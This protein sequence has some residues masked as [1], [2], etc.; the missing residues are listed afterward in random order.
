MPLVRREHNQARRADVICRSIPRPTLHCAYARA[1]VR[2][3][4][5]RKTL[6]GTLGQSFTSHSLSFCAHISKLVS[7]PQTYCLISPQ[8]RAAHGHAREACLQV[9]P[10][11]THRRRVGRSHLLGR[12]PAHPPLE[13][14]TR[15]VAIGASRHSARARRARRP[16]D[17]VWVEHSGRPPKVALGEHDRVRARQVRH[18]IDDFAVKVKRCA[19]PKVRQ[20]RGRKGGPSL[21]RGKAGGPH[22]TRAGARGCLR[23]ASKYA[24]P[25]LPCQ[26]DLELNTCTST[27]GQMR[28]TSASIARK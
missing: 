16:H 14:P 23:K 22:G 6:F 17:A 15:P 11:P 21:V 5:R 27:S 13:R 25:Q 8:T 10:H 2:C 20:G 24:S 9:G 4:W 1:L 26:V 19:V 3:R 7:G 12:Q 18:R 28:R